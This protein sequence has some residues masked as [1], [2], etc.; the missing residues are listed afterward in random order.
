MNIL[1]FR[2]HLTLCTYHFRFHIPELYTVYLVGKLGYGLV[3]KMHG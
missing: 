3:M 2:M 1:S